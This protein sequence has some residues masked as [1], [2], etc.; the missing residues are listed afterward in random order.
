VRPDPRV[1]GR[2]PR[3]AADRVEDIAAWLLVAVALVV[4]VVSAAVGVQDYAANLDASQVQAAE[5]TPADAVALA[6]SPITMG[7]DGVDPSL[8]PVPVPVR[9]TGADGLVH[10]S[11]APLTGSTAV[12]SPVTI[13]LDRSGQLVPPPATATDAVM[14]A[15]TVGG[16]VL[17]G[18]AVLVGAGWVLLRRLVGRLNAGFWER[19]WARV[20]PQWTGHGR[21]AW[22]R[23]S[24]PGGF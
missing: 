21:N 20:G 7:A 11:T 1:A 23:E 14:L 2:L 3:R 15:I 8:M 19:E 18:G 4:L 22:D 16:L 9:W 24:G 17:L 10:T 12:G 13:W 6:G 5:R